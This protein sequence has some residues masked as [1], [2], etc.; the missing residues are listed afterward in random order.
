ME[1]IYVYLGGKI[2]L[3]GN[4]LW[5]DNNIDYYFIENLDWQNAFQGLFC[6]GYQWRINSD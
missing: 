4:D 6:V 1:Y 3:E 5:I 2:T